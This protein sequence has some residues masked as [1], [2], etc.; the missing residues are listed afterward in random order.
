MGVPL[1]EPIKI[2]WGSCSDFPHR[3]QADPSQQMHFIAL[4]LQLF[5]SEIRNWRQKSSKK[6]DQL[7]AEYICLQSEWQNE[8]QNVGEFCPKAKRKAGKYSTW[9]NGTH[10]S[11]RSRGMPGFF[12][13]WFSISCNSLASSFCNT[14]MIWFKTFNTLAIKVIYHFHFIFCIIFFWLPRLLG[15]WS[16]IYGR[17][18]PSDANQ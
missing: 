11:G 10:C 7:K 1:S 2:Q 17:M 4:K 15:A 12:F 14:E 5:A 3:V 9:S 16:N 8:S 13:R 6:S 18:C